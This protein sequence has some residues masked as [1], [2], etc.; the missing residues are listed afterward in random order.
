MLAQAGFTGGGV[1][2]GHIVLLRREGSALQG[3]RSKD[4]GSDVG[5]R[6]L[7]GR[8]DL[9]DRPPRRAR[10]LGRGRHEPG[11]GRLRRWRARRRRPP[12]RLRAVERHLLGLGLARAEREPLPLRPGEHS[13]GRLRRRTSKISRRLALASSFAWT[14][15]YT[16]SDA[17]AGPLGPGWTHAY[18]ASLQVQANGDV[19]A[20]GEEGQEVAFTRQADGSFVGDPG[21]RATLSAVAGGYELRRTDQVVYAFDA[22]G[23]LLAIED[24]NER[25]GDA[26]V[27]R[28]GPAVRVTDAAGRR[29]TVSYDG[30]ACV[31][32]VRAHDGR[33]VSYGYASGR[34]TSV[35]DVRGKAWSY[36]YDAGGRLATIVDPLRHAQVTN[37]Y[38]ADGRVQAQTDAVGKRTDFAWDAQD[39]DRDRHRCER[40][41]LEARLRPRRPR[42]GDRPLSHVT[43][44]GHDDELNTDSVTSPTGEDADVLRRGREPRHRDRAALPRERAEDVRLQLAQRPDPGHGRALERSPRTPT[45]PPGTPPPSPRTASA[46]PRTPTTPPDESSRRR[47]GT[48]RRRRTPTLRRR[49]TSPRSP[50]RSGTRRPTRTTTPAAWRRESTRR[51]TSPAA[52]AR[53]S[54]PRRTRTTPPAGS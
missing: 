8:L 30:S 19:L 42:E 12:A 37:V 39:R 49:A 38:G 26:R 5:P 9:Y 2:T 44:L 25:G 53:R 13:H 47:T 20:R 34:L 6:G 28:P 36:T 52:A 45:T 22:A 48:G 21:A 43:E 17:T 10:L 7:G 51:G 32:A 27:R 40:Q 31:S 11:L 29:A 41:R 18:A 14:R 15:T 3:W 35:S 50:T 33:S 16:S 24:R 46:S 54:S 1:G 23:R 4:G